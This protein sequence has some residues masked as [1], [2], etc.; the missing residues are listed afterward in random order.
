MQFDQLK[1]REFITLLGGAAAWPLVARAQQDGRNRRIGVLMPYLNRDALGQAR[2]A[3]FTEELQR[4]GWTDG[5]NL[6]IAVRWAERSISLLAAELVALAP[7]VLLG[8]GIPSVTA[9]QLETRSIPIVFVQLA[10]PVG[11]GI[12]QSLARP[13]GNVTGFLQFD[14]TV[15]GKWLELLKQVAP[16][17]TRAAVLRNPAIASGIQFAGIQ[18][19]APSL[20]VEVS[21]INISAAA[22]IERDVTA[23]ARSTNVG[24]IV[25]EPLVVLYSDVILSLAARHGLPAIYPF[26]SIVAGGGLMSYGPNLIDPY[27]RAAG[28]VDRILRGEKPADLPVQAPTKY[29]LAINLKTAKALGLEVPPTLLGRADE[30]IE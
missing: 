21:A 12:V 19:V 18:S 5:R 13:G 1:R 10:D 14:Y 11:A 27:R 28:Y 26:R 30:V 6:Q 8:T 23:F 2:L 16:G 4:L 24:L 15:S 29:D 20:G 7:D 9:L 3:A 25:T 22:E 17:V